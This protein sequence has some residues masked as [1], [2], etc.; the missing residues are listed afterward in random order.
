MVSS[1][2]CRVFHGLVLLIISSLSL[3]HAVRHSP[4]MV[5]QV[6]L[7]SRSQQ[8]RPLLDFSATWHILGPFQIGTRE[9]PWGADPFTHHDGFHALTHDPNVTY[10]SSLPT[11]GT[12]SWTSL[13]SQNSQTTPTS[14]SVFLRVSFDNVDWNFLRNIY[15]WAATQYQAWARGELIVHG[16]QDDEGGLQHVVLYTDGIMEYCVDDTHYFGGDF[17]SFRKAPLVL[18]LAPGRHTIELRLVRDVRA[19]GGVVEPMMDVKVEVQKVSGGLEVVEGD[20]KEKEVL[21]MADIVDGKLISPWASVSL[22]NTGVDEVE[23]VGVEALFFDARRKGEVKEQDVFDTTVDTLHTASVRLIGHEG[24]NMVIAAEQTRPLA[25]EI[26]LPSSSSSTQPRSLSWYSFL[27]LKF[28][29]TKVGDHDAKG[30]VK[31]ETHTLNLTHPLIHTSISSPHKITF[32]HPGGIVS[33]AI[34]RPPLSNITCQASNASHSKQLNPIN[35]EDENGRKIDEK[36]PIILALHGAGLEASNPMVA[37]SLDEVQDLCAWVLFPTGVTVWSGDD[38]HTWGFA[39]VEAAVAYIPR[40]IESVGWDGYGVDVDRWVVTGH[41][42]GGQGTWY[43]LTHRP[44]KIIAAAPLSGYASIQKYV[45]YE[46][47]QPADPRRTAIISVTLNS[48]RHDMLL[49][50]AKGIPILTQ[51]GELDDNV[52][53][54]H[55]RF[56]TQ[57]LYQAGTEADDSGYVE[58]PGHK[59]WWDG[60]MTTSPL[61]QFYRKWTGKEARNVSIPRKLEEFSIVVGDPGDMGSKGGVRV[62]SLEDPGQYG[63]VHVKGRFIKTSNVADLEVHGLAKGEGPVVVDGYEIDVSRRQVHIQKNGGPW[64]VQE[65]QEQD[66]SSRKRHG[67]QLGTLSAILRTHGPFTI[68]HQGEETAHIALQISRNLHQYF[69]ADASIVPEMSSPA[70]KGTGN[71]VTVCIGQVP[72]SSRRNYPIQVTP[73]GISVRDSKGVTQDYAG[74]SRLGAAFLRPL[75]GERLEL[76]LWGSDADGL[77]QAARLVPTVAGVGQPDF[78]VLGK[79]AAWRGVEGALAMGFFD[80]EWEVTASSVVS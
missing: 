74:E 61:K 15:G 53:A 28:T 60:V 37:H 21:L 73:R 34:L 48:Y 58:V 67:R 8:Q 3:G 69:H 10:R 26:S 16:D 62:L 63:R 36:L 19:M 11:N 51:H 32:L 12:V 6:P 79:S 20:R 77:A 39:D 18:H 41:S 33:Y 49:E 4:S 75:D 80:R 23:V 35:T 46:F 70:L 78:V 64:Q 59:H 24:K 30:D 29:Y 44:D 5:S 52:P 71:V 66:Y 76:V 27:H 45:P 25:F 72:S 54:Y 65:R 17:Y 38:W 2:L 68:R 42:N 7:P 47:W 55:S 50:N 43:A 56:L 31:A 40:W 13:S 1:R 9:A 22:T 57:L 14:A